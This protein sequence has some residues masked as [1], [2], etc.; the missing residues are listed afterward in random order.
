MVATTVGNVRQSMAKHIGRKVTI[1]SNL[2]RH[3]YDVTEGV[4][5]ETYPCIFLVQLEGENEGVK[6]VSYS[7]AD[8]IT[9]DVQLTLC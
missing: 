2:G 6:T 8:V 3:K 7:Y 5:K 4:I 9:Q 1:R